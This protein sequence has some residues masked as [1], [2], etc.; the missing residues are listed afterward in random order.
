MTRFQLD[1]QHSCSAGWLTHSHYRSLIDRALLLPF[2]LFLVLRSGFLLGHCVFAGDLVCFLIEPSFRNSRRE[3]SHF[4]KLDA[5][6]QHNLPQRRQG[7]KFAS[8]MLWNNTISRKGA[9]AQSSQS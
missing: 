1:L 3:T 6:E 4:R 2:L 7:A 5:L 8:L 9:E